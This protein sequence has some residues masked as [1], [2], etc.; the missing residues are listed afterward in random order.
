MKVELAKRIWE[1]EYKPSIQL[2]ID[3]GETSYR[4]A[5]ILIFCAIEHAYRA[6][7]E[8]PEKKDCIQ[9]AIGWAMAMSWLYKDKVKSQIPD[10]LQGAV[11]GLKQSEYQM[12][13]ML[14]NALKHVGHEHEGIIIGSD[15]SAIFSFGTTYLI[16]DDGTR[17]VESRSVTLHVP[18]LWRKFAERLDAQYSR[19]FNEGVE[20]HD[21]EW[22]GFDSNELMC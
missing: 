12:R 22:A 19:K 4:P 21:L 15:E 1:N 17:E 8:I 5:M 13:E 7:H 6:I 10:R 11:S 9:D 3:N 16:D 20:S 18:R 2:L 14:F